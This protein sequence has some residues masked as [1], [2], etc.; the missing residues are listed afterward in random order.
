MSFIDPISC[1]APLAIFADI[2]GGEI[3]VV[4]AAILML[5]GGKGVPGIARTLGKITKDLQKASQDFKDQLLDADLPDDLN[6]PID[7]SHWISPE[8][9]Y[10]PEE[11]PVP[12]PD[13][14]A[15][16]TA[17]PE[18]DAPVATTQDTVATPE[19][20]EAS[21]TVSSEKPLSP[22]IRDNG[23]QQPPPESP[24]SDING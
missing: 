21:K 20:T 5:F 19:P 7:T 13:V 18:V 1:T 14:A 15:P 24:S 22:N 23:Y 2:G 12:P 3:L 17:A 16:E 11:S 10:H 9:E 6:T 4:L 8:S